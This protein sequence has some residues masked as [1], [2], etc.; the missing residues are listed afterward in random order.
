MLRQSD[1]NR[2]RRTEE[3]DNL[4]LALSI[5]AFHLDAFEARLGR[6]ITTSASQPSKPVKSDI[7][8]ANQVVVAVRSPVEKV[9]N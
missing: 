5:F 4:R 1:M 3:L 7:G 9:Q 2:D 8:F 6:Q